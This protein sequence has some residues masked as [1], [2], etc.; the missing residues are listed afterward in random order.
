MSEYKKVIRKWYWPLLNACGG[1]FAWN[2]CEYSNGNYN[3][4]LEEK[5][6]NGIK[7]IFLCL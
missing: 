3:Y 1:N 4:F 5:T 7:E 6:P 2:F